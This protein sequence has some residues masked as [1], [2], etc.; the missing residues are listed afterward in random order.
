MISI[1]PVVSDDI[2]MVQ[3][4]PAYPPDF[5]DLD[6]ALRDN[7]WLKEYCDKPQTRCYIAQVSGEAVGFAILSRTGRDEAEF[8]VA[9]RADKLG[10]GLG[11]PIIDA[12]L[13]KAFTEMDLTLNHKKHSRWQFTA[14]RGLRYHVRC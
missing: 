12:T 8:R 13:Q 3:E 10:E 9:L 14:I 7:G 4:W 2:A 5:H 6:Y 11:G 1:R